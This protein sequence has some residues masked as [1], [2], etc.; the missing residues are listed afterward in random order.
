MVGEFGLEFLNL[1]L[2]FHLFHLEFQQL[3]LILELGDFVIGD[4]DGW[5]WDLGSEFFLWVGFCLAGLIYI[6]NFE[7]ADRL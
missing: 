7:K 3:I 4:L 5:V 2:G 6:A 1:E